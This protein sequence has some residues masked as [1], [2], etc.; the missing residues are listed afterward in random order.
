MKL[1]NEKS[2]A[3]I[4]QE[5]QRSKKRLLLLDY[6]GT[7]APFTKEPALAKPS[8][9]LIEQLR[10]MAADQRNEVVVISGRDEKTLDEWLGHLRISLVAEHGASVKFK[11]GEWQKEFNLQPGW[12]DSIRPIMQLYV[13]RCAGS[14]LEEKENT[15]A[16][17]YR[18]TASDLGFN[19]SRELMNAISQLTT[20]TS[21][22]IIDGNKVLEV[23]QAGVDKGTIAMKLLRNFEPD[24]VFC[25]GD[26]AT[27]EDMFSLLKNKAFTLRIGNEVT[28]ADFSVL[29]QSDVL[30]LLATIINASNIKESNACT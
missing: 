13:T 14:I 18:N 30:P 15:L 20:N 7:L 17:H 25:I 19:R 29:N 5:Y 10:Q 6:D 21:L 28:A 16:W 2:I 24:F 23:R 1:L 11:G 9:E 12:K 3:K 22:Q 27:D 26:D 4:Q 8:S